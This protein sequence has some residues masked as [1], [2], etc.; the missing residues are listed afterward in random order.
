MKGD[1]KGR[2]IIKG[3]AKG[4]KAMSHNET[5]A[6]ESKAKRQGRYVLHR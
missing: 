3:D 1:S 2:N 5:E 4:S 6:R